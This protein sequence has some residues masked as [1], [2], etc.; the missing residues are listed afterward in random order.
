MRNTLSRISG[1][2]TVFPPSLLSS[3]LLGLG[4]TWL[5]LEE[6]ICLK[7]FQIEEKKISSKTLLGAFKGK[8]WL[9]IVV[10]LVI[11]FQLSMRFQVLRMIKMIAMKN[12][13]NST[14]ALRIGIYYEDSDIFSYFD[15]FHNFSAF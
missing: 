13:M 9:S 6:E 15:D 8:W 5:V 3:Y 11:A 14:I 1:I 7:K 10:S 12:M 2:F 4:D